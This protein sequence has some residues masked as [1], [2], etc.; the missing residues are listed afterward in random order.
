[1]A[2]C[3]LTGWGDIGRLFTV[4][5]IFALVLGITYLTT[6]FAAGFAK[7]RQWCRNIEIIETFPISQGKYIQI[8]RCADKYL[9]IAVSKDNVTLLTE[10]EEESLEL[11]D[12]SQNS[13]I[14]EF[15][16]IMDQARKVL[17][18]GGSGNEK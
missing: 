13:K 2:Y 3:L 10:L 6:R 16:D 9:A 18:K 5:V 11:G 14:P 4:I 17:K 8:V 7:Q 15:K 12:I 1:M